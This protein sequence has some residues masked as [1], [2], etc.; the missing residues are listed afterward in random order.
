VRE[1]AAEIL[2]GILL[3]PALACQ[4]EHPV[5]DGIPILVADLR[6]YAGHQLD[7]I[8]ARSD[9][10]PLLQGL[11][12]DCA[13]PASGLD[14]TRYQ[15][16][17]YARGHWGDL[18]AAAPAPPEANVAAL[19]EQGL[20]LLPAP[21]AGPW[22]D[23]GCALGRTSFELAARTGDAVL[24]IDLNFAMLQAARRI[25]RDGHASYPL[26]RLGIVYDVREVRA[27]PAGR[28]RVDFWAADA[29]LLPLPA[30]AFAGAL[31][32]N[33]LDCVPSPLAH[34]R[35]L[36]R[37]LGPGGAALLSSPYDWST[38]ATPIEAWLGG[39]SQRGVT[40]GSSAATVRRLLASDAPAGAPE[41]VLTA[42]RDDV[43]WQV[44][45]HE[46]AVTHYRAHLIAARRR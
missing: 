41:L 12:G 10:S 11:L 36:G 1:D 26:R 20:A 8:L 9:L 4:R 25:A 23:T 43:P 30:G 46:R 29:T 24:G 39:H 37:A 13:G 14:V 2:E 5:V 34:L 21:P 38:S 33:V 16:G 6:G 40:G 32:L 27:E 7:A 42:E 3:C 22:L 18:D 15:L 45:L 28:E 17:T 44:Y 19:L 31:S 35:E